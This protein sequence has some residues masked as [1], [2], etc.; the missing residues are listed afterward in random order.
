MAICEGRAWQYLEERH[1]NTWR[2]GVV[3]PGGLAWQY[4]EERRGN[5]WKSEVA[6][7]GGTRKSWR[8]LLLIA[9]QVRWLSS[10]TPGHTPAPRLPP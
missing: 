8:A 10:L 3:I 5:T 4:L 6:I 9:R 7:P 2:N 1:C